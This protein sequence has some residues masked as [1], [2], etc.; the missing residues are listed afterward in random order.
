MLIGGGV[1]A[2]NAL[3][4][5]V[6]EKEYIHRCIARAVSEDEIIDICDNKISLRDSIMSAKDVFVVD[7]N[8]MTQEVVGCWTTAKEDIPEEFLPEA[9]RFLCVS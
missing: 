9:G 7:I 5:V 4:L 2:H 3:F 1:T 8:L 6:D